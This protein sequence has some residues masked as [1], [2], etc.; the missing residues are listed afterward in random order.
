MAKLNKTEAV[1]AAKSM[2]QK[3]ESVN[4]VTIGEL[5]KIDYMQRREY[6]RMLMA[7]S[8]VQ[9]IDTHEKYKAD[10]EV[11]FVDAAMSIWSGKERQLEN[12]RRS[13][14]RATTGLTVTQAN[15]KIVALVKSM[16]IRGLQDRGGY[17]Y[18]EVS[19]ADEQATLYVRTER[20]G[21]YDNCVVNPD[22]DT[23]KAF[24]HVVT[25][26]LSWA[27]TSRSTARS[28]VA[29]KIYQELL[30]AANEIEATMARENI[31]STWGVPEAAAEVEVAQS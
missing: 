9:N 31:S 12:A 14:K 15:E 27:G 11:A 18:F 22:D 16:G 24:T 6:A 2:A 20:V 1:A 23:Q 21:D 26:E 3:H 17:G 10:V 28:A 19:R 29:I 8:G 13:W 7:D 25:T 5:A 4:A 30:D